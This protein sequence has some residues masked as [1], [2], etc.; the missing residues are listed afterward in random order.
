MSG[1]NRLREKVCNARLGYPFS[2]A[3]GARCAQKFWTMLDWV[4]PSHPPIYLLIHAPAPAIRLMIHAPLTAGAT[5][6]PPSPRLTFDTR[7]R[8]CHQI[9]GTRPPSTAG[10]TQRPPR[11]A[12]RTKNTKRETT[13]KTTDRPDARTDQRTHA[14]KGTRNSDRPLP[15]RVTNPVRDLRNS[16]R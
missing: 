4:Q 10:A 5:Q 2:L 13:P 12:N 15:R 16:S 6:R 14:K 7:P 3:S 8:H 11:R 1:T 9:F